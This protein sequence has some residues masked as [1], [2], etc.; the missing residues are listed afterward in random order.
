MTAPTRESW[1]TAGLNE[2]IS[3]TQLAEFQ[4]HD[5]ENREWISVMLMARHGDDKE[6]EWWFGPVVSVSGDRVGLDV[7][8]GPDRH[9]NELV[10]WVDLGRDLIERGQL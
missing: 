8:F 10:L 2:R 5:P 6:F 9:G 7:G 1:P 4:R 3:R